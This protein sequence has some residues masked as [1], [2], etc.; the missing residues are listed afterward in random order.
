MS[1]AVHSTHKES[2][3]RGRAARTAAWTVA[4]CIIAWIF[5][6]IRLVGPTERGVLQRFGRVVDARVRPGVHFFFPTGVDRVTKLRIRQ[7]RRAAV[8]GAVLDR[9]G[10]GLA[11][12]AQ[13]AFVTGD[14]N[15]VDVRGTAQYVIRDAPAYLFSTTFPDGLVR[16]AVEAAIA[17]RLSSMS[18]DDVL[19]RRKAQIQNDVR[20]LAQQIL[21]AYDCGV[22]VTSV[23]L[24]RVEP[25]QGVR[26][27]FRDV[28][29]A[30]VD[31]RRRKAEAE[32]Y[33]NDILARA[34]GEAA[35]VRKQ[36]E[37]DA[38]GTVARARGRAARFT[39]ILDQAGQ[40]GDL[41]RLRLFAV[42]ME[43]VL[44]RVRLLVVDPERP[45]DVQ[46]VEESP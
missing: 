2:S 9:V 18:V 38:Y 6:G 43:Q 28:I 40:S 1:K 29:S 39:S 11:T 3:R 33:R 7:T 5:T 8:G 15:I 23:S 14:R 31:A 20:T 24:E 21:D 16:N 17:L 25:P 34:A 41:T 46:L 37:A 26:D 42:T 35:A 22:T 32:G 4:A 44:Q 45:T 27:A 12:P 13:S 10:G 30:R 36:A 19:T